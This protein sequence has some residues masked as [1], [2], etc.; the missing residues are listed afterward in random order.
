VRARSARRLVQP[1]FP[2][3]PIDASLAPKTL[4][5]LDP[6]SAEVAKLHVLAGMTNEEVASLLGISEST[7]KRR[8]SYG[9]AWIT[10][11]L[12][13]DGDCGGELRT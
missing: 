12:T 7:V 1:G 11:E 8:W 9:K 3:E 10:R 6:D 4:Q 2:R 13:G 5:S